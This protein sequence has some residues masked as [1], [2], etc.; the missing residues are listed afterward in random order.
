[1]RQELLKRLA[2]VV[3]PETTKSVTIKDGKLGDFLL[4]KKLLSID[5]Y[6][7]WAVTGLSNVWSMVI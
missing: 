2:F 5:Q 1:M 6:A 7:F 3:K 4:P